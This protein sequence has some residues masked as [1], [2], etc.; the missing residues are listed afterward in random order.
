[1]QIKFK[2]I[3][4]SKKRPL[5]RLL[6]GLGI[7]HI[8]GQTA[9][10]LAKYFGTLEK[11]LLAKRDEL[12]KLK[13]IEREKKKLLDKKHKKDEIS[14]EEYKKECENLQLTDIGDE[15]LSS[16]CDYIENSENKMILQELINLGVKPKKSTKENGLGVLKG[17]NIVVTGTLENFTR[18]QIEQ[19]IKDNGGKSTSSVSKNTTFVL[20]GE[21]PG[22]KIKKAQEL[23]IKI[24]NEN[25]FLEL[26][27]KEP[28]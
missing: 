16:F 13:R 8:G 4:N 5:W 26:I 9:Q 24:I 18:Q 19:A 6:S 22:S 2:S 11:V 3:R 21:N 27:Q 25:Q 15:M 12:Q 10:T 23:G 28:L 20:A 17:N 14:E 1:M 7:R